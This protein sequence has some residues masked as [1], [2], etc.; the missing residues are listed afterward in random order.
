MDALVLQYLNSRGFTEAAS[1]L[2]REMNTVPETA[3][4][5]STRIN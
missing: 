4:E 1:Q 2:Q 5:I 3:V